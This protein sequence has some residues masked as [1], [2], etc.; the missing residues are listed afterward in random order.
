LVA[1]AGL[2]T[3]SVGNTSASPP[4]HA[5]SAKAITIVKA[6]LF[7]LNSLNPCRFLKFYFLL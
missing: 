4:P 2:E 3:T 6:N 7:M 1:V 5:D